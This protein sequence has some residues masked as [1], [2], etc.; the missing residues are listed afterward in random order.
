MNESLPKTSYSR[1]LFLR[2][3]SNGERFT[4]TKYLLQFQID[5]EENSELIFKQDDF[6]SDN[7]YDLLFIRLS[8]ENPKLKAFECRRIFNEVKAHFDDQMLEEDSIVRVCIDLVKNPKLESIIQEYIKRDESK[9]VSVF[10]FQAGEVK[11]YFFL[12]NTKP[13]F[14]GSSIARIMNYLHHTYN[15]KEFMVI[16]TTK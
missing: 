3:K 10:S 4:E 8:L 16:E 15:M 9:H 13:D 5:S 14:L 11:E 6:L 1:G 2:S 12:N 7:C